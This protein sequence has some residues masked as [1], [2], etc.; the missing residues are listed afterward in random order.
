[1]SE[2]NESRVLE[3]DVLPP[4]D[5]SRTSPPPASLGR[6]VERAVGPVAAGLI[7]D[8]VDL[9]TFGPVGLVAGALIGGAVGWYLARALDMPP[10]W[11][12]AAVLLAAIYCTLP[13]TEFIPA[14]TLVGALAR[15]AKR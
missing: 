14:A 15:Y 4:E 8:F 3:P 10:R 9:G 13:F 1:M 2:A 6:R 5:E 12:P 7:L 11:R